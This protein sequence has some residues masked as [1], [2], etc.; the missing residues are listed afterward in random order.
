[1]QGKIC[2]NFYV[3]HFQFVDFLFIIRLVSLNEIKAISM[4]IKMIEMNQID[5]Q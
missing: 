2:T 4:L 5:D 1:M 3:K